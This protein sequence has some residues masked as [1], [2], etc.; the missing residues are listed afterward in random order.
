MGVRRDLRT[1]IRERE[2]EFGSSGDRGVRRVRGE[3]RCVEKTGHLSS[4]RWGGV[5]G[6]G[7][8]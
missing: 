6:G 5:E 7:V 4:P 2:R 3:L 8:Q 1:E